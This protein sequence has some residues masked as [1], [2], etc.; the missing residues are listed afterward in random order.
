MVLALQKN[1]QYRFCCDFRKVIEIGW[2]DEY[3][4]PRL[5]DILDSLHGAKFFPN[6]DLLSAFHQIVIG[7]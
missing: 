6:L 5:D 7:L 2:K 4:L 1:G 3:R